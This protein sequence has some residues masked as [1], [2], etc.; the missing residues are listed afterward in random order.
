MYGVR[1]HQLLSTQKRSLVGPR[2]D[3]SQNEASEYMEY[4]T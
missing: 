3:I 1:V 2:S 4:V